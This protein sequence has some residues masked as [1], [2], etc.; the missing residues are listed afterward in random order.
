[1]TLPPCLLAYCPVI[2]AASRLRLLMP[3]PEKGS[4]WAEQG[5]GQRRPQE[6]CLS[7]CQCLRWLVNR[8]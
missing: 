5:W 8:F 1:M 2:L 6:L 3:Q 7:Q 4:C